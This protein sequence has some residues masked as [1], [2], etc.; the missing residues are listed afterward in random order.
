MTTLTKAERLL[1]DAGVTISG[2]KRE[3]YGDPRESFEHIARVW[4]IVLG[5][6][7]S[8]RQVALCMAGLKL[9][10]ESHAHSRDNLLDG[11]AYFAL[12]EGLEL[13]LAELFG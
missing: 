6:S 5:Q 9:V 10:R 7:V 11:A 3:A 12:A 13:G 2:P 1:A 8:C 4:S